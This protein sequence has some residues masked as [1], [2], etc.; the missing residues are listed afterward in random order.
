MWLGS[1]GS[2][3]MWGSL[4]GVMPSQSSRR[5]AAPFALFTLH[6]TWDALWPSVSDATVESWCFWWMPMPSW[7]SGYR[8]PCVGRAACPL[9]DAPPPTA[10]AHWPAASVIA[11][12]RTSST[13]AL[14]IA[15]PSPGLGLCPRYITTSRSGYNGPIGHHSGEGGSDRSASPDQ[16]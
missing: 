6:S 15:K 13:R 9:A 14:L 10:L 3:V 8:S 16:I 12:T 1:A 5:L 4:F 7:A 2:T 11:A